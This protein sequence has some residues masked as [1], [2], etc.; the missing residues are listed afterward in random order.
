[1]LKQLGRCIGKYK[2]PSFL[3]S[4]FVMLEVVM[5]VFIPYLMA[6]IIDDGIM[7][8]N[9]EHILKVGGLLIVI[10][11]FSLMFG[12]LSGKNA[13]VASA[14]FA[15][16][17][18]KN[19]FDSVQDF[20]FTEIDKY[21]PAGIVTRL[22]T[23]ITN[24]QNSYQM[25]IRTAV[26]SPFMLIFSLVMAFRINKQ[27]S[28][29]FLCIIPILA[30][31]LYIIIK[32]AH[33]I[34]EWVFKTYDKL[35]N[36]VSENLRGIRV[37]KSF[38]REE[39][40]KEKFKAI[41]ESIYRKTLKAERILSGNMPLMQISVYTCMILISWF[42]AR[43]IVL[44]GG[45]EM[46][47]GQLT[48]LF[49][50]IMQ[51]L[52]S[53]MMFSMIFVMI[54]MSKASAERTAEILTEK[55]SIENP[56]SPI[57]EMRDGEIIF[58]NVSFAYKKDGKRCLKNIN[59]NIKSGMTV[60]IIGTTGSG[61]SSL[62]QLIPRLYDISGG[63]ITV[64]GTD[65][66]DYDIKFLRDNVAMVL[67]KNVLFSGTIK[68][69]LMWG[70]KNATDEE[71]ETALKLS[72]AY[73]FVNEFPDKINTYIE[74]GGAN[75]SGGQRQRLCIARAILKKPKILILDDSTSAVDTKTDALIR[76][77]MARLMPETT[78][79]IIAQRISSVQE[80]DMI[81]V[82]DNGSVNAVGTHDELLKSCE[83][84]KEVYTS[85]QKGGN[86]HEE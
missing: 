54:I 56:Q 16:N 14:G 70:N 38:V 31:G 20:S 50:Y 33:P 81:I 45:T 71:I 46:T 23:D 10:A 35:N 49:S 17:L 9:M 19:M 79:L 2:I 42:G 7:V 80:S 82:M 65:V 86:A 58:D 75:V 36:V 64:G 85:Q 73:D 34:F 11:L 60:G 78:K 66:R 1:M 40:E 44:S 59:L 76:E 43:I 13:A 24:L 69:N 30:I 61:K 62:V 57:T 47:T 52:M 5:E 63:K 39:H 53:L 67:Q 37:V 72:Q 12:A 15:K 25:I 6:S 84:Y 21:S 26:R 29:I 41:S 22:T 27:L 51:I 48:S 8:K 18:R 28:F 4:A 74:Q 77:S 68:E 32:N 3:A 83:I 55:T